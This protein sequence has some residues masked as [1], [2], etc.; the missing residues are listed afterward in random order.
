[1]AWVVKKDPILDEDGKLIRID[2]Y[3]CPDAGCELHECTIADLEGEAD[4]IVAR[5]NYDANKP[6][7]QTTIK[8]CQYF[9]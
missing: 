7:A 9:C 1:M 5:N 3:A 4:E 8:K 2:W 6:T